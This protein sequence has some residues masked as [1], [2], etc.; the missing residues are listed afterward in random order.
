MSFYNSI[1]EIEDTDDATMEVLEY[2]SDKY[3]NDPSSLNQY[4]K[5]LL[6]IFELEAEV[7]NGGFEQ[8]F[9][10]SAGSNTKETLHALEEIKA[11]NTKLLLEK[12][13]KVFPGGK[14]EKD[15]EKRQD[16]IDELP[17]DCQD[18]WNE[19]DDDFYQYEDDIAS[20][21]IDYIKKNLNKISA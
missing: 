3:D 6:N 11:S 9:Y 12:A 21:V 19:L 16:I 10:N 20:L 5:N 15:H 1:L 8:Y 4:E 13:I 2:L 18:K 7:N 14:V 17:E